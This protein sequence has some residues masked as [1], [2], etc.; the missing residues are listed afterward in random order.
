MLDGLIKEVFV[1]FFEVVFFCIVFFLLLNVMGI[2][3]IVLVVFGGVLG[4]GF[5]LGL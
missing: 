1:K 4:V 2:N 5:G 3:F